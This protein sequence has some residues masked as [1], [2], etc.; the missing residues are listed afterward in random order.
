MEFRARGNGYSLDL[1]GDGSV[2]ALC[3]ASSGVAGRGLAPSSERLQRSVTCDAMRMQLLGASNTATPAGEERLPGT[4]NYFMGND[5]AKWRTGIPTYAKVRY[6]G[7]YSGIDLVYYGN[8]RELEYDF[9]VAPGA[10][11]RNIR[12]RL[13]GAEHVRRAANGDLLA[14]ASGGTLTLRRPAIYQIEDGRRIPA[15]G[16][17]AL[18]A[19]HTVRFRLGRFDHSK[20]LVIDPALVYS[21]FFG[22]NG[23]DAAYA[24]AVDASG[25]AYIA[26]ATSSTTFPVTPGAFQPQNNSATQNSNGFVTKLNAAGTALVYSTYLGGSGDTYGA[27]DGIR[28]LAVDSAGD[29]YVTGT[30]GSTDFPITPGAFQTTN[31]AAANQCVT[32]FV[33]ELNPTGTAL[34][35]SSFLGGSGDADDWPFSGDAGYGIAVDSSGN[36]HL[37]GQTFSSNFPV[38][39]GALQTVNNGA[40]TGNA[41]AFITKMN[42]TG[43]AL[44]YSTYL[45][46]SK[47]STSGYQLASGTAIAVDS[48]GNAYVAG[49]ASSTDFPVTSGAFQTTQNAAAAEGVNA[50]VTKLNPTGTA[51]VYSTYLGGSTGD[52]A[53]AVAVDASGNAYVAGTA[54]ST[55]FPVTSGAFQSTNRFTFAEEIGPNAFITKLNPAG[56]ALVYSTYLGG[57]GGVINLSPTLEA[58]GGDSATGIAVDSSGDAYVTGSTASSNFPVTQGAFQTVNNDQTNDSIGG[59]NAFVTELNPTGTGLVYST[60]LGGNGINAGDFIGAIVF[61]TGDA[62]AG[63]ALDSANNVYIAG[64]ASSSDFPVTDGAFQTQISSTQNAFIAKMD[65][66]QGSSSEITPTVTLT[67]SAPTV[68]SAQSL[69]VTVS[70]SSGSGNPTPTGSVSLSSTGYSPAAETLSGGSATF[71]VAEGTLEAFECY[72]AAGLPT[73]PNL[74]LASYLPDAASASTYKFASGQGE[75]AVV[76]ACAALSPATETMTWAQAQSQATTYSIAASS[77]PGEPLPTGAVTL[78]TGNYT[79]PAATLSNGTATL[80][81]PAGTFTTGFNIVYS[82]YGG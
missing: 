21:T 56:S 64:D 63:L 78:S 17:F 10:D 12:L 67:P 9:V 45:G 8:H 68:T 16:E 24:I 53:S 79:S 49:Q 55:N 59:N 23:F 47:S 40:A 44:V 65:F 13:G 31:K 39:A 15:R 46:G 4:V 75:A 5:P 26:G 38:T 82:N 28:A 74:L 7:I 29:A 30:A 72:A 60:Y 14:S 81:I 19:G 66:S 22:G 37:T 18:S 54:S 25:E 34:V 36:A 62:A 57:S 41:N 76:G 43:T 77:A 52:S 11:P 1:V 2:L 48:D 80:S 70:V 27:G 3:H 71:D 42:A 35:Y 61:G 58:L 51:L 20:P 32:A 33:T 73:P 69:T 6:Q 50:F